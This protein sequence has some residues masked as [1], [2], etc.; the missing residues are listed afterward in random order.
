M[1]GLPWSVAGCQE[2]FSSVRRGSFGGACEQVGQCDEPSVRHRQ[3]AGKSL[4]VITWSIGVV[5]R[6]AH[7]RELHE[8]DGLLPKT[9]HFSS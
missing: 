9:S 2:Y 5:Y 6:I 1:G 7:D 3:S 8:T 4:K